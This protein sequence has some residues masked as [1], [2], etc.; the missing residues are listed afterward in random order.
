MF[1]HIRDLEVR[2]A[3]FDIELP[4]GSIDFLDSKIRQSRPLKA[5]G[6][7]ELVNSALDEI[8]VKGHLTVLME[9]DCD[10]CLEPAACPVDADFELVYR[11]VADG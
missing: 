10:R 5:S 3:V 8:R 4:P 11:P 7:A 2:P 1:F 6:R 9:A